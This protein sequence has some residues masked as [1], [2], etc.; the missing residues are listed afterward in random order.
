[1]RIL[2][3]LTLIVAT[4]W[5]WGQ[6]LEWDVN[7]GS[8]GA[9]GGTGD[10]DGGNFWWN[11]SSN[12]P[13]VSGAD[14]V[15][16]GSAGTVDSSGITVDDI[17]Y[18]VTGYNLTG[19]SG[20]LTL[21]GGDGVSVISGTGDINVSAAVAGSSKLTKQG[22]GRLSL[23]N[24]ASTFNGG[25]TV[26]QGLVVAASGSSGS[27]SEGTPSSLGSSGIITLGGETTTGTLG[28][29]FTTGGKGVTNRPFSINPGGGIINFRSDGT[30]T[31]AGPLSGTGVLSVPSGRFEVVGDKTFAGTLRYGFN[32]NP[33]LGDALVLRGSMPAADVV[34]SQ[35]L[36]FFGPIPFY[37]EGNQTIADLVCIGASLLLGDY[38]PNAAGRLNT[39]S[40][41]FD[42]GSV[43]LDLAS[44]SSYD[45]I[46]V[47]GPVTLRGSTPLTLRLQFDP[48][49]GDIFR[50]IENDGVDP[51][52]LTGRFSY[53]GNVLEDGEH[54]IATTGSISQEF[55][56][57][58]GLTADDND[59]RLIATPE[60]SIGLLASGGIAVGLCRTRL[61]R[62]GR[63][64]AP[65]PPASSRD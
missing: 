29:S 8:A 52:T 60:P 33:L 14:A 7:L 47:T 54:F 12:V 3:P 27:W 30:L 16:G 48:T 37:S 40:L 44:P 61:R 41:D 56:I 45:S 2:I 49:E 34:I 19:P 4:S 18:T 6:S 38:S 24:L 65:F 35:S 51:V 9:Q 39:T 58:Y 5:A 59:V 11:G 53:A 21:G 31:F 32:P 23:N 17:S 46:G 36:I 62:R 55:E 28:Y 50:I 42:R 25:L 22:S 13:W 64:T 63:C 10:W 57:R 43:S 1:M 26:E 20:N 15:F